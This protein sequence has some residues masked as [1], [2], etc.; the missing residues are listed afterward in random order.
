M[1]L[2]I[3]S[4]YDT[5]A[6][7]FNKPFTDINDATAKRSFIQS[8]KEQPHKNDY[9][10]YHIGDFT[11]HDGQITGG[12]G[13]RKLMSG[14]DVKTVQHNPIEDLPQSLKEQAS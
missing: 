2:S 3:Y 12:K 11:D 4:I 10:L 1:K 6:E 5:V 8:V 13:V 14:F 7:V 9:E